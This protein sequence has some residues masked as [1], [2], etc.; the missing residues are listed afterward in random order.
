MLEFNLRTIV[1]S[2]SDFFI[3]PSLF[4]IVAVFI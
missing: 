1:V 3:L 4:E 2:P